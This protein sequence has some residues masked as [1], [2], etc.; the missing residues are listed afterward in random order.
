LIIAKI[1]C[2]RINFKSLYTP[3]ADLPVRLQIIILSECAVCYER[4]K[5][6]V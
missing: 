2:R 1:I 4:I 6:Y 5:K 3:T